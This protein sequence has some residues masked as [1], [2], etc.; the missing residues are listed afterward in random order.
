MF[1]K[2]DL[3]ELKKD[4]VHH[5]WQLAID[6]YLYD[7]EQKVNLWV[8][9]NTIEIPTHVRPKRWVIVPENYDSLYDIFDALKGIKGMKWFFYEMVAA[10]ERIYK[11]WY[12]EELSLLIKEDPEAFKGKANLWI[13]R[14]INHNE[15]IDSFGMRILEEVFDIDADDHI[16]LLD[17]WMSPHNDLFDK[18]FEVLHSTLEPAEIVFMIKL[19]LNGIEE[20]RVLMTAF[21][22]CLEDFKKWKEENYD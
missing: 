16:D 7:E 5:I 12:A 8:K 10:T 2:E 17:K 20:K 3:M 21:E 4:I 14:F 19:E 6:A 1:T 18:I 13:Y 9:Y 11:N 22:K 15:N